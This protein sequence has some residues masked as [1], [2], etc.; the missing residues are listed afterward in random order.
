[1]I[2]IGNPRRRNEMLGWASKDNR[3]KPMAFAVESFNSFAAIGFYIHK[4]LH[5]T[6]KS[7]RPVNKYPTTHYF[8]NSRH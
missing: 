8:G 2:T 3:G 1:M 6:P 7:M 5:L 4:G